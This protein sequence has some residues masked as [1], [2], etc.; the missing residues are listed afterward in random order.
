MTCVVSASNV[1]T[2][3]IEK[4]GQIL[5]DLYFGTVFS[6]ISCEYG[7]SYGLDTSYK[8]ESYWNAT[9]HNFDSC[10][11]IL[12]YDGAYKCVVTTTTAGI[13]NTSYYGPIIV[14]IECTYI[15]CSSIN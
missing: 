9:E 12:Y 4:N 13:Q 2:L 7:C 10:E 8:L 15:L 11:G 5:D 3:L 6:N 1:D 14:K